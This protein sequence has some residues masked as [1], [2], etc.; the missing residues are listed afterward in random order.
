MLSSKR[1]FFVSFGFVCATL[2][3][4][5]L[6]AAQNA[7][8]QVEKKSDVAAPILRRVLVRH[9]G[10]FDANLLEEVDA[11]VGQ[12]TYRPRVET[13]YDQDKVDNM[14]KVLQELWK[15]RGVSVAVD[16][17]LTQIRDTHYAILEFTVYKPRCVTCVTAYLLR[18]P[19]TVEISVLQLTVVSYLVNQWPTAIRI[20][21]S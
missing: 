19:S 16:S 15:E 1:L 3:C 14:K 20:A 7:N 13:P 11:R 8:S 6:A 21:L 5:P 10:S 17:R 4:P 2:L 18:H 9:L 12:I